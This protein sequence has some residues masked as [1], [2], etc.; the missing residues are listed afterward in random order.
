[1]GAA[2]FGIRER[3]TFEIAAGNGIDRVSDTDGI[4]VINVNLG[5][6]FPLGLFVVQDGHNDDDN[7]NF[8]LVPWSV[9]ANSMRPPLTIDTTWDPRRDPATR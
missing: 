5:P 6:D 3:L 2:C 7:Q 8:K 1:M 4:D 9:I